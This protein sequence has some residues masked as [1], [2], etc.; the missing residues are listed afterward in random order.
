M[1]KLYKLLF[2]AGD[3]TKSYEEFVEQYGDSEKSER[4]YKGLNEAGDYTK[5]FEEFNEQFGFNDPVK[6]K[7][8]FQLPGTGQGEDMESTTK[9]EVVEEER[10]REREEG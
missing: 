1:E 10:R 3:Y 6:K 8:S 5:S 2:E 4:L 9:E 7:D